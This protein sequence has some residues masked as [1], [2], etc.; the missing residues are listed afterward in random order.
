MASDVFRSTKDFFKDNFI[1]WM[2]IIAECGVLI[3]YSMSLKSHTIKIKLWTL[4]NRRPRHDPKSKIL[5]LPTIATDDRVIS[6][7]PRMR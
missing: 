6:S 3:S 2:Y 4:K 7:F 1:T 5:L